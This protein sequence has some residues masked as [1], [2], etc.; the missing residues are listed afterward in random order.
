MIQKLTE[1][2]IID[3]MREEW[4][5]KVQSLLTEKKSKK[6]INK[7][8]KRGKRSLQNSIDVD[9]DGQPEMVIDPGL[10]ITCN[11]GPFK[12]TDYTIVS[13]DEGSQQVK[14]SRSNLQGKMV[15]L[16]VSFDELR[17]NYTM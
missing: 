3:L 15:F 2:Y 9:G 16:T 13:V 12:G 7:D 11:S 14:L 6:P 17:S 1:R 10:R 4:T 5:N 8:K